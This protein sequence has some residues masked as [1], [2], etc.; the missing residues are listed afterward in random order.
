MNRTQLIEYML[1]LD[2]D[3]FNRY[4]FLS[5]TYFALSEEERPVFL[6]ELDGFNSGLLKEIYS[7]ERIH[8]PEIKEEFIRR[9][10]DAE[11]IGRTTGYVLRDIRWRRISSDPDYPSFGY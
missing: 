3:D 8:G 5:Q 2:I 10:H 1:N 6:G 9:G 11:D 4:L 7:A